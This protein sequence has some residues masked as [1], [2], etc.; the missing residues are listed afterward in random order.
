MLAS[1]LSL[2]PPAA[3]L[4]VHPLGWDDAAAVA[5]VVLGLAAETREEPLFAQMLAST[6]SAYHRGGVSPSGSSPGGVEQ[7]IGRARRE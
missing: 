6:V 5:D 3:R 2:W 7:A 4:R 1:D